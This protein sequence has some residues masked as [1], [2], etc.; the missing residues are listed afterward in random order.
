MSL[1]SI[2][3]RRGWS[4]A[5]MLAAVVCT[6]ISASSTDTIHAD[7]VASAFRAAK[8]KL[9]QD[10]RSAK[11][12]VRAAALSKLREFP[13]PDAVDTLLLQ[14]GLTQ[15]PDVRRG[16]FETL[17]S[18]R[19]SEV[20]GQALLTDVLR[21]LKR[22]KVEPATS[23]RLIVLLAADAPPVVEMQKQALKE[24]EKTPA[25]WLLLAMVIDQ[26]TETADAPAAQSLYQLAE[27]PV[28]VSQAGLR[29]AYVQAL[30][31]LN[32]AKAVS[33]LIQFQGTAEGEMRADIERRLMF[34]S[35]L[36]AE[37]RPDWSAWW[38]EKEAKFVF[39]S[40]LK[41]AASL[42][43]KADDNGPSYYGLPLYGSQIVF[44][45]D[46]S[47]SMRGLQMD[48]A[49]RELQNAI[50]KLPDGVRFNIVAFNS[51]VMPW[52]REL[53]H[54]SPQSKLEAIQFVAAGEA[55]SQTA[56]YDALEA[57]LSQ[58]CDAIY[59]LTD[60]APNGGK[61]SNPQEIITVI[62]RQ[63]RVRRATINA[64][65]IGVGRDGNVFDTFLRELAERNFGAYRRLD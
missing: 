24:A 1:T 32:E 12:E 50:T 14:G 33:Q 18:F 8:S 16:C 55:G 31:R 6:V 22:D 36:K 52:K 59:F 30:C 3:S 41:P 28:L 19:N 63:N 51:R 42:F 48:A 54:V 10:L 4:L 27:L 58:N 62:S 29:R 64:I 60:G 38:K 46:Y 11:A 57:A 65:G 25:G 49:K 53:I 45:I 2:S 39:P 35:G 13:T 9:V 37:D 15:F 7:E 40:A 26:L 20:V 47:G 44:V 23:V 5:G 17:H 21:D 56:S 61:T 43:A 34:L